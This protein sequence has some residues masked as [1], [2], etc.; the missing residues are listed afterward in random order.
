MYKLY[1]IPGSHACRSAMLALEHK[2]VPYRCVEIPTLTHP[3]A[4]RLFG[5]G[6][7]GQTRS[8]GDRRTVSVRIGDLLGT[9]PALAAGDARVSTNHTI[10]RFLDER[11]PEPPLLP[12]DPELL[13]EVEA[14]EA[15]GNDVFQMAA[16][17]IALG[18]TLRDDWPDHARAAQ[19]G[20]MGYLLYPQERLRRW[21]IPL[22]ARHIFNVNRET[23]RRLLDALPPML[24]RIDGWIE[25]GVLN[26]E[27]LN[28]ADLM[29]APGLALMLYRPDMLTVLE[30]RPALD[31]V[32]R[33]LPA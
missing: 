28:A 16:R 7:G 2:R 10:V 13:R 4:S 8:V 17:R 19:D 9:V 27:A 25:A 24:D 18:V 33:L 31:L 23:E 26:G 6:A 12:G 30:E 1:V 15:W 14:A 11:H 20:R 22:I 5:F 32:D 21:I 3:V 29:I